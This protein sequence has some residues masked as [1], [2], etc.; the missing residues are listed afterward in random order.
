M[1]MLEQGGM[2]NIITQ[3][4]LCDSENEVK[5]IPSNAPAGSVVL[6]LTDN[7]LNVKM[8]DNEGNWKAT[9]SWNT[10]SYSIG[11]ITVTRPSTSSRAISFTAS[12]AGTYYYGTSASGSSIHANANQSV[13]L[14]DP[15][16]SRF[17]L[18]MFA[19]D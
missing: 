15:V 13:E 14:P 17:G 18:T 1:I 10:T 6:I 9:S 19:S 16:M 11:R 5:D 8:K 2:P 4:Y 3:T 12:V 7:G